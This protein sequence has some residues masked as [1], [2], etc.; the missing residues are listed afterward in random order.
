MLEDIEKYVRDVVGIGLKI[1]CIY[2][3]INQGS[4]GNIGKTLGDNGKAPK[5][6]F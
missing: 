3:F 6:Y 1:F 5:F 2:I 4:L